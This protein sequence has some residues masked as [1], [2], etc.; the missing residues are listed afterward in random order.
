MATAL[1]GMEALPTVIATGT[2]VAGRA[3]EGIVT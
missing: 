3:P 2:A 1:A